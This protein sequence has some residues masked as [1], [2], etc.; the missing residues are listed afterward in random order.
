MWL[1]VSPQLNFDL[2]EAGEQVMVSWGVA[3]L[4]ARDL[5]L[6]PSFTQVGN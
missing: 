2:Q 4:D 6:T 5:R 1:P 3:H